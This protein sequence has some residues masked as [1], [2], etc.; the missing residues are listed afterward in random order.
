MANYRFKVPTDR[1]D[2]NDFLD[3]SGVGQN[4]SRTPFGCFIDKLGHFD[5]NLFN[6]SPREAKQI[7][8]TQRLLLMSAYEAL[9]MAGYNDGR[10]GTVS[11]FIGQMSDNCRGLAWRPCRVILSPPHLYNTLSQ[12]L[13]VTMEGMSP[14]C[15]VRKQITLPMLSKDKDP[16]MVWLNVQS[17]PGVKL[18]LMLLVMSNLGNTRKLQLLKSAI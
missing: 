11:T 14:S 9:E 17:P 7:D 3:P 10:G 15:Q 1:F 8:P 16:S 2:V 6:V 13:L 18:P 5:A 4:T 12:T